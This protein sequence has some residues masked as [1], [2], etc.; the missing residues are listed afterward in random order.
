MVHGDSLWTIARAH[1][2]AA[3][4]RD[5]DDIP[6]HELG[7]YWAKVVAANRDHLRSRDPDVIYPGEL[8]HLPAVGARGS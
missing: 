3:T 4:G 2:A 7:N 8:I 6:V 5:A 1:L